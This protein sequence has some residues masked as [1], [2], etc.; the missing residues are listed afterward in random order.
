[1]FQSSTLSDSVSEETSRQIGMAQ[2]RRHL[3]RF[4]CQTYDCTCFCTWFL[5][6]SSAYLSETKGNKE[7]EQFWKRAGCKFKGI[8]IYIDIFVWCDFLLAWKGKKRQPWAWTMSSPRCSSAP[9]TPA[10][11]RS[12]AVDFRRSCH[13]RSSSCHAAEM[14]GTSEMSMHVHRRYTQLACSCAYVVYTR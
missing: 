2:V 14:C 1:M 6:L 13:L 10:A 3:V 4:S 5:C 12:F 11:Y 9:S 7:P 8:Y